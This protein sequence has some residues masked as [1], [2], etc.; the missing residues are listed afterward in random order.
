MRMAFMFLI[1]AVA[2]PAAQATERGVFL[3]IWG[4]SAQC[5]GDLLQPGGTVRA[6]P[7]EITEG[8]LRH[9]A[10]WCS[11]DWFPA[12]PR[13]DGTFASTRALCG[14]DSQ[15]SYRLDFLHKADMDALVLIWDEALLNGPLMRCT[16]R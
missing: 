3:G 4:T 16:G 8:W 9:G 6:V 15:R 7:F 11:L 1:F 2:A 14:E 5:A 13:T 10:L 12:V